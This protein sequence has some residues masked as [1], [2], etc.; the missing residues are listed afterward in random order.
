MKQ[1]PDQKRI[2]DNLAPSAVSAEGFLG[3]DKR[4]VAA[5]V[6]ADAAALER[7]GTT[8]ASL[9]ARMRRVTHRAAA[10][11]GATVEVAP[12]REASVEEH[13]G[14]IPCPF[15]CAHKFMKRSTV[16]T[17]CATGETVRYTDLNVHLIEKHGFFEGAGSPF[18]VE[19]DALAA[20]LEGV[21]A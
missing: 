20:A 1:T 16:L 5:I 3:D 19:P 7:L 10:G 12:G 14:A 4:D 15:R 6:A 21:E 17:D 8:A 9:A 11:L 13:R 18:R 2:Q